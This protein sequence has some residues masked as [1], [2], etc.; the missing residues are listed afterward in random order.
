MHMPLAME[1]LH[2]IV[3][4][5]PR[6]VLKR[7][8]LFQPH[9]L[10][11]IASYVY[12]SMLSLHLGVSN[13]HLRYIGV[14]SDPRRDDGLI[15]WHKRRSLQILQTIIENDQ[16]ARRVQTLKIYAPSH[17]AE[18]SDTLAFQMGA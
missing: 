12:F 6:H 17:S 1:T 4:Y 11:Q 15:E 3:L 14:G 16:F 8:L 9:P 13:L 10:G 18:D 2:E 7:L 5:L